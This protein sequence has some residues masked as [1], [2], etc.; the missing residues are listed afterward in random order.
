MGPEEY[1]AFRREANRTTGNWTSSADDAKIFGN[2]LNSTGTYW[3]DIF[4]QDGKQSDYQLGI[5]SGTAKTNFYVS[6]SYFNEEGLL[7]KDVLNRY[8]F[9][10]N[11]DHKISDKFQFGTQN[12][13]TFYDQDLR[14]DPLGTA[15]KLVPLEVPYDADGNLIP[16]INNGRNINPLTD[17]LEN[18]YENNL[19]TTRIFSSAYLSVN[20]L[21]NLSL[22]SNLGINLTNTR[23]GLYAG[24][25]PTSATAPSLWPATLP[26]T[27]SASTSRT[28]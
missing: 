4:L 17:L 13:I 14:F 22:K 19:R 23:E 15:N 12:Q 27:P 6:M 28:S 5:T 21:K 9:R 2:L 18:N 24:S 1:K 7:E 3:P 11:I 25:Q 10:A 26:A 16:L 20:P 8:N